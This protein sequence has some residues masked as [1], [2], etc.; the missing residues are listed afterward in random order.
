MT[1]KQFH[2]RMYFMTDMAQGEWDNIVQKPKPASHNLSPEDSCRVEYLQQVLVSSKMYGYER[3]A[4]AAGD[5]LDGP[6]WAFFKSS[7]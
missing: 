3:R 6:H 5:G 4:A 2:R 1:D 7:N